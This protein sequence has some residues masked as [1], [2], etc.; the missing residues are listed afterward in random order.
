[1]ARYDITAEAEAAGLRF[2]VFRANAFGLSRTRLAYVEADPSSHP[3]VALLKLLVDNE[4][5]SVVDGSVLVAHDVVACMPMP[6]AEA[7]GLPRPCPYS[8]R[9]E[10]VGA[11]A[12]AEFRVGIS[13]LAADGTHAT[14]PQA[15]W[16]RFWRASP[17]RYL[18]PEP[19]YSVV[20]MVDRLN[21][22]PKANGRAALDARMVEFASLK[23]ALDNATGD[24]EA[25][26][27]LDGLT[28]HH[29]TGLAIEASSAGDDRFEP[30]LFGDMPLPAHVSPD[31]EDV[32]VDR[33]PLLPADHALK[34]RSVLFQNQGSRSHYRLA[35]GIYAVLSAPVEAA[36]SVVEK[37]NASDRTTRA[38]FRANPRSFLNEAIE[39]AGG[40]GDV[41]CES[42]VIRDVMD[43]GERVLG[44]REW[45]G[46]AQLSFKVPV[47]RKWFPD[48][49][50]EIYTI[51]PPGSD[52]PIVVTTKEVPKLRDAVEQAKAAGRKEFSFNG[53]SY[54]LTS[55]VE[56]IVGKLSGFLAPRGS[57]A[58][59]KK[60]ATDKKLFV[61][62]AAENEE[63]LQFHAR[64]RNPSGALSVGIPSG[65]KTHPKP[66]QKDGIA[67]LQHAYL[68]G[69]PGVLLA[70]DMGVGKTFQ[71]LALL[72]WMR[73][74]GGSD[75]RP[76]LIVAPKK[77]LGEWLEQVA[78]H[79]GPDGLGI[80]GSCVR[81]A[82]QG[83]EDRSRQRR[84]VGPRDPRR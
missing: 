51:D 26:E 42:S 84:R 41:L 75:P 37:V 55:D 59:K 66:H 61:L 64:L 31:H 65:L 38:A 80:A 33:R 5:A 45:D 43:Y 25:S 57:Q 14:G 46:P 40:D 82:P 6:D 30:V 77:L 18:L 78:E 69:M 71:V 74:A 81:P 63:D 13:W 79:L 52:Q 2:T 70:D 15:E 23:Q 29:A 21:A 56:D 53:K 28:I 34:F 17:R 36:L 19:L 10:A 35:E 9:L 7:L 60:D 50:D 72:H 11:L 1:M 44:I 24:A 32:S 68:S 58:L 16:K 3:G 54:P 20:D 12:D 8:L 62:R 47:Y 83:A 67:W 76:F 48:E 4:S 49:S 27:Y 73:L 39:A 22:M